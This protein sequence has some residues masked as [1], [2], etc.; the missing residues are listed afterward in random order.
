MKTIYR[1]FLIINSV[2]LF[3][4][5]SDEPKS[6][7]VSGTEPESQ[8]LTRQQAGSHPISEMDFESLKSKIE[9]H[10]CNCSG[11][12][13]LLFDFELSVIE[14]EKYI[15]KMEK[16]D[17][18]IST[19]KLIAES[20]EH[21]YWRYSKENAAKSDLYFNK[22]IQTLKDIISIG[23]YDPT[24]N[25]SYD[26]LIKIYRSKK[27]NLTDFDPQHEYYDQLISKYSKELNTDRYSKYQLTETMSS[28]LQRAISKRLTVD[29]KKYFNE[30][31]STLFKR[32]IDSDRY[33]RFKDQYAIDLLLT[34]IE[35]YQLDNEQVEKIRSL[36][37]IA[38]V[39]GFSYKT[40]EIES[41]IWWC[42]VRSIDDNIELMRFLNQ[43]MLSAN[44]EAALKMLVEL[45]KVD[46]IS[47]WAEILEFEISDKLFDQSIK[48]AQKNRTQPKR[49]SQ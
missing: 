20:Y 38:R 41:I 23:K 44:Q 34:V 14:L 49:L 24:F 31:V 35:N 12:S 42:M 13:S 29:D 25:E 16:V 48:M 43:Q 10:N 40:K 22:R 18:T 5:C 1:L 4:S 28:L 30:L 7:D 8:E 3:N 33:R 21:L 26:E 39:R 27:S 47:S 17:S 45:G 15:S 6:H 32:D 37:I 11:R 2:L 19:R 46:E 9:D 36:A